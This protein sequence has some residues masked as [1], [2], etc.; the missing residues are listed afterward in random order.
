MALF[1]SIFALD[2]SRVKIGGETI[3]F[4]FEKLSSIII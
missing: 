4:K 2:D 3:G 1:I